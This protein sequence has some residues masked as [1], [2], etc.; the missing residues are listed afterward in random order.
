MGKPFERAGRKAT[1]L[2][3]RVRRQRGCE[4]RD[5]KIG[6]TPDALGL[7]VSSMMARKNNNAVKHRIR[8]GHSCN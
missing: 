7:R 5:I 4:V 3:D 1:D 8:G 2:M 6:Y